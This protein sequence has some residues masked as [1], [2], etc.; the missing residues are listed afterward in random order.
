MNGFP[1]ISFVLD[2][3]GKKEKWCRYT[4]E[5]YA[6]KFSSAPAEDNLTNAIDDAKPLAKEEGSLLNTVAEIALKFAPLLIDAL[7]GSTGPSQTDRLEYIFS[8]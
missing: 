5:E 8:C 3:K 6:R 1:S 2:V 7:T 4:A